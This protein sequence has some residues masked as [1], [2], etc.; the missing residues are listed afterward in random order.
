[1]GPLPPGPPLPDIIM[2]LVEFLGL[3][4]EGGGPMPA[5]EG[6]RGCGGII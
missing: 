1:M 6:G 3:R 2:L 4:W 5:L